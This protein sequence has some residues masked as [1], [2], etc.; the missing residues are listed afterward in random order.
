MAADYPL[1][2]KGSEILSH[3]LRPDREYT[4]KLYDWRRPDKFSLEQVHVVRA[5]HETFSRASAPILSGIAGSPV[6][7][8]CSSVDQMTFVE[9]M[10]SLPSVAAYLPLALPPLKG[11]LLM[12]LD[13]TLAESLVR[14]AT[15]YPDLARSGAQASRELTEIEAVVLRDVVES[16]LPSLDEAWR[17]VIDLSSSVIDVETDPQSVQL[18]PA[19][20]MIL[21]ATVEVRLGE[22]VGHINF[23]IPFLTIE[24]VVER[25][26][27]QWWYSSAVRNRTHLLAERAVD[28]P[29]EVELA[30]DA[31]SVAIAELPAIVRGQPVEL[32]T[33]S[34]RALAVFAG[35]V[36]VATALADTG[37]LSLAEPLVARVTAYRRGSTIRRLTAPPTRDTPCSG[38]LAD[39]LGS[40]EARVAAMQG[41]LE[42][43]REDRASL[44]SDIGEEPQ[45]YR[46]VDDAPELVRRH[47]RE[48]ALSLAGEHFTVTGFVL[49]G[50]APEV[51][52]AVLA[53]LEPSAQPAVIRAITSLRHGD[54]ELHRKLLAFLGRRISRSLETQTPG[55]AATS[56]EILNH[57]P[58]SVEKH[59]METFLKEEKEL[60]DRIAPLMFVFEDF[61]LLDADAI[62]KVTAGVSV[63]ELALAMK[64]VPAEVADHI[65]RAVDEETAAAVTDAVDSLGRVRRQDVESAQRDLIEELRR[66]EEAGEVVVG[67]TGEVLE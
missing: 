16:V 48:I 33:L 42:E 53:E 44:L 18:V 52:A 29:V 56:A 3:R 67:R 12:Q 62:R 63:P 61:V 57:V 34:E 7:L 35:G 32:P 14:R 38:R 23:A 64:G 45:T 31:G 46:A 36:P 2:R 11:S 55:G 10:E 66:L 5:L 40:L 51:A 54:R 19:T 41:A 37:Q 30:A 6:E 60:F 13:G 22:T 21:L 28:I 27:A 1:M 20:E 39:A 43:M 15:G 9:F 17:P 8:T 50:L 25:L 4:V 24:P 58:R 49:S 65:L 59:V 26:S 47:Q